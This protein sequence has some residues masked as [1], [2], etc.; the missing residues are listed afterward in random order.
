MDQQNQNEQSN[1]KPAPTG[2]Q[3]AEEM[4]ERVI[5]EKIV[6]EKV[7]GSSSGV[8]RF[9]RKIKRKI[10]S[11]LGGIGMGFLLIIISF[12]VV[13]QSEKFD[14]S[15]ELVADLPVL[16]AEQAVGNTGLVKVQDKVTSETIKSPR[17]NKEVIY[18]RR[19]RQELKMVIET[20]TET[21]IIEKDGKDVE[22]IIEREVERPKWVS[23]LDEEKWAQLE[24]GGKIQV[25]PNGARKTLSLTEVYSH[26]EEKYRESI[27][28]LLPGVTLLVVGEMDNN[29]IDGGKPFIITTNSNEQLISSLEESENRTWW[30]LKILTA[31]LFG[32]G[33]YLLLGPLL[34]LLDAIPI[35]GNMGKSALF[36][37]AIIIGVIFTVFS[38][39]LIAFWYIILIILVALIGYLIYQKKQSKPVEKTE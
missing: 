32:I 24:L 37:V 5:S 30:I 38:S 23:T 36:I 6:S 29:T 39:I 21:R 9:G 35:L 4:K 27:K 2:P 8:A 15:A 34:L 22:Q 31:L 13:W 11:R 28:A 1:D 19:T 12:F 7:I 10:S 17:E 25:N 16:S 26:K 18:Y 20:E 3:E 33:L 14:R